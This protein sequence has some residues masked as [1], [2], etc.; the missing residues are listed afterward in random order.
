MT[1]N[2]AYKILGL[3]PNSSELDVKY[4]Y[5]KLAF[6]YHPD[7]N[8][9]NQKWA[10]K[11]M[12]ELNEAYSTLMNVSYDKQINPF[13]DIFGFG[14]FFSAKE[15]LWDKFFNQTNLNFDSN[16]GEQPI[17]N[18]ISCPC[19]GNLKVQ[20]DL[21]GNVQKVIVTCLKCNKQYRV[22]SIMILG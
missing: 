17:E 22:S 21:R 10:E 19:G 3:Y 20:V 13:E 14:D 5:R 12:K 7:K 15:D 18:Q 6:K 9:S 1:R 11:K 16:F 2:D 8:M 4:A